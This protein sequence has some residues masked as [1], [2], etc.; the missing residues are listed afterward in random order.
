MCV[1]S[2]GVPCEKTARGRDRAPPG[3][4]REERGGQNRIV[5]L[6]FVPPVPL[7]GGR[8]RAEEGELAGEER[9]PE[10][11]SSPRTLNSLVE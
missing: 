9:A 4:P 7:L 5:P 10:T 6:L 8:E 2:F 11:P 1:I 3:R